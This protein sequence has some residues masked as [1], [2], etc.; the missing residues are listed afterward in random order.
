MSSEIQRAAEIDRLIHEPS[1]MMIMTILYA[2]GQADFLYLQHQ[3]GL[4]RGNLSNH[5]ARLEQGDYI[6]IEKTFRG[7]V[8][9]TLLSLTPQGKSAFETYR[10]QMILLVDALHA[11]EQ[12]PEGKLSLENQQY[13]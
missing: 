1:R 2:A 8:P 11:S 3:T 5:L 4:T 9:Q 7:K 6:Q 13:Q 12:E 10:K